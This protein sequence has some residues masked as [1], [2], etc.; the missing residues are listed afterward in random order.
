VVLVAVVLAATAQGALLPW[1]RRSTPSV[2]DEPVDTAAREQ[3]P[4]GSDHLHPRKQG[5]ASTGATPSDRTTTGPTK[6]SAPMVS[7][8]PSVDAVSD[9]GVHHELSPVPAT[10][11]KRRGRSPRKNNNKSCDPP[12]TTDE[13]GRV[14]FKVECM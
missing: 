4:A 10:D 11:D 9:A 8:Q 7:T 14:L 1:A 12:Y 5:V 2:D 3:A 6:T 13:A